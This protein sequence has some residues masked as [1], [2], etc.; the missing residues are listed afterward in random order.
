MDNLVK[1][2]GEMVCKDGTGR[3]FEFF[4]EDFVLS[5]SDINQARA[6]IR[7]A[8]I[9]ERLRKKEVTGALEYP[10]FR[11]VR[12]MQVISITPT[13]EKAEHSELDTAMLRAIELECIPDNLDNYKRPDYKLKALEKAIAVAEARREKLKDE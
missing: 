12:T 2:E 4:E 8:M 13:D 3:R 5:V 6:L 11:K 7:K 1:V 9:E 10:D